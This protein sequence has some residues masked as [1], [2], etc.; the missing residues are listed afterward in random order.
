MRPRVDFIKSEKLI[1]DCGNNYIMN[2]NP[3][4]TA[5]VILDEYR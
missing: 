1:L 3:L 2:I 4:I 5:E